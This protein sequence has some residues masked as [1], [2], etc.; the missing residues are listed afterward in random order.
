MIYS[1]GEISRIQMALEACG[2][3][4]RPAIFFFFNIAHNDA[5]TSQL[6]NTF[7]TS[8]YWPFIDCVFMHAYTQTELRIQ[9]S[10]FVEVSITLSYPLVLFNYTDDPIE[11]V[12]PILYSRLMVCTASRIFETL[13][14]R[15]IRRLRD[16]SQIIPRKN[17]MYSQKK[18]KRLR[19]Q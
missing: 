19:S 16:E 3:L 8:V 4:Y 13:C 6:N 18:K 11:V 7:C 17:Q 5:Q 2:K 1:S 14:A 10:F 15:H 12:T 9:G